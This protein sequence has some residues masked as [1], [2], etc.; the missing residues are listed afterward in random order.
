M[1]SFLCLWQ[2][3]SWSETR[4]VRRDSLLVSSP[5]TGSDSHPGLTLRKGTKKCKK[6]LLKC[7][8]QRF[9]F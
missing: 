5:D 2:D 9:K 4:T 7:F 1:F 3:E 8:D 6:F